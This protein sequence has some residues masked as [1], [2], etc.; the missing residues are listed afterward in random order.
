[1]TKVIKG[2]WDLEKEIKLTGEIKE[3]IQN[4]NIERFFISD[5]EIKNFKILFEDNRFKI[6][7][8][9]KGN[10]LKYYVSLLNSSFL[11]GKDFIKVLWDKDWL[12]WD[13]GIPA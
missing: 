1:M 10:N 12:D 2:V 7:Y 5:R 4:K 8:S 13:K 9:L 3:Y 11:I 6:I